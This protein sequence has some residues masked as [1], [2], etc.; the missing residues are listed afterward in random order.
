MKHKAIQIEG[1][2][3]KEFLEMLKE[4]FDITK[5][6]TYKGKEIALSL[7]EVAKFKRISRRTLNNWIRAGDIKITKRGGKRCVLLKEFYE[8]K[9][10]KNDRIS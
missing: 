10:E 8:C 3:T 4:K 2:D 9:R 5:Q 6:T 7:D 1:T